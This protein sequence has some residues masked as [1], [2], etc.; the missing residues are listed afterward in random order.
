MN[1]FLS[2]SGDRSKALATALNTWHAK[3]IQG[4]NPWLSDKSIDPGERWNVELEKALETC[5]YAIICVTP[6][7]SNAPWLMFEAGDA[8]ARITKSKTVPL[9]CGLGVRDLVGPC[10]RHTAARR[11]APR[12]I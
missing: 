7:N 8:G 1:V 5:Q 12:N 3:V 4:V 11:R 10:P 2:W 9:C 6:E